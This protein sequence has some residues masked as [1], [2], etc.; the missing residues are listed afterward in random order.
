M[1]K[2]NQPVTL[3][4]NMDDAEKAKAD[5]LSIRGPFI[6]MSTPNIRMATLYLD[7]GWAKNVAESTAKLGR[8]CN[9]KRWHDEKVDKPHWVVTVKRTPNDTAAY[10]RDELRS[11]E[12]MEKEERLRH[13]DRIINGE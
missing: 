6:I 10:V 8:I 3:N 5:V 9:V 12:D 11:V 13:I 2:L 4:R 7:R 1:N